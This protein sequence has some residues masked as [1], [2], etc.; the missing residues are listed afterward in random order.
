MTLIERISQL[1]DKCGELFKSL[2]TDLGQKSSLKT[3]NKNSL[4]EAINELADRP[5][6]NSGAAIDDSQ[7]A[8]HTAYSSQK[9]VELIAAAKQ[10]T[11][12]EIT[13]EIVGEA[14]E[15]YNT[16]KEVSDYIESDSTGAARMAEQIGY[17]LRIDETQQLS[18]EQKTAVEATLNLGNTDTDFAARLQEALQ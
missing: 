5:Q 8:A 18:P 4:V 9:T 16:L 3:Q 7:A 14:A 2:R 17:R 1:A 6:G 15:A 10:E 12:T 11:K 13:A